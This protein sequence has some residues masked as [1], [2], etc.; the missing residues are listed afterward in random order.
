MSSLGKHLLLELCNSNRALLD[1]VQY[2]E[3][4][5]VLAAK[6][7]GANI[8]GKLFHKFSPKGVTG[9]IT[10]TESH[11]CIHTWPEHEYAAVDIFTCGKGFKPHRAAE[12][13][14]ERLGCKHPQISEIDRGPIPKFARSIQ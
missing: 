6:E 8:L 9:V 13:I 12:I 4:I 2:I 1:D 10:I 3:Q 11:L 5:M 7:A 14:I